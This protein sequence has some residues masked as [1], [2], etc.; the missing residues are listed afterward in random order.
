MSVLIIIFILAVVSGL[1]LYLSGKEL[2][3]T[4]VRRTG[5]Q[6]L[7]I[8][9]GGANSARSALMA[10]MNADPIGVATIDPSLTGATLLG[11]YAGG[12]AAAQNPFGLFDYI[13]IDGLRYSLNPNPSTGA[14]TMHVNWLLPEPH[15]KLQPG[16]GTPSSNTLGAGRYS[17]QVVI[18]RRGGRPRLVPGGTLLHPPAPAG[19]GRL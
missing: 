13:V 11:W 4:A 6:S 17:G 1:I 16:V 8:A 5:A 18:S 14:I 15:R 12:D 7:Y 2:A 9:E 19:R 10:M 3:L